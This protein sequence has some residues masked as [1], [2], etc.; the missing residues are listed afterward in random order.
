MSDEIIKKYSDLREQCLVPISKI[1]E[2]YI[3]DIMKYPRIDII[4]SRAKTVD[5]FINKSKKL[6]DGKLKYTEPFTQI[7]D[8]IGVRITTF[9]KSDVEEIEKNVKKYFRSIESQSI[10][11]DTPSKFGYIGKHLILILP[12]HI[13]D[14][15]LLEINPPQFFE[16][17]IK[18]L[19]QHAWSQA[20]HDLTYKSEK[21]WTDTE[22]RK[23]A[24]TAAQAW[25]A[26]EIFNEMFETLNK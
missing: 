4:S 2:K 12:N 8:Q 18:T 22:L 15:E 7:Q 6:L 13:I 26:D 1:I 16:L 23:I 9:Y 11:S 3:K 21:D 14:Q 25:G 24:F 19:F 20:E 5:S 17:Q 10:I